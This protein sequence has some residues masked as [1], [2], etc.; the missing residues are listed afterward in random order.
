MLGKKGEP[1]KGRRN[2]TAHRAPPRGPSFR[3]SVPNI[4]FLLIPAVLLTGAIVFVLVF[5]SQTEAGQIKT[6]A[7]AVPARG[8]S[9]KL[10]LY[11]ESDDP[12]YWGKQIGR[13]LNIMAWFTYWNQS[14][15]GDKLVTACT[16]GYV[17]LISWQSWNGSLSDKKVYYL[18]DIAKGRYDNYIIRSLS[19][20]AS[21]C[22]RETVII[23]FDHEMDTPFPDASYPWQEGDPAAYVAAWRHVVGISHAIDPYIKWLWSPFFSFSYSAEFYPGAKWVDYVGTTID[24]RP[25]T[26]TLQESFAEIYS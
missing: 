7:V 10:G 6:N 19:A 17:P 23:R 2:P 9:L 15:V 8:T 20:I 24:E 12:T 25:L 13:R 22:P 21:I 14:V 16:E 11:L 4:I 18:R 26:N 3:P 5:K 1:T